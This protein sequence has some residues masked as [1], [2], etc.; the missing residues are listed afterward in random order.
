LDFNILCIFVDVISIQKTGEHFR[1]I[2][3]VKGRFTIHRITPEEA[4]VIK[5]NING[6]YK[7]WLT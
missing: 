7:H 2:Y 5:L 4:K 1:L 6:C 3:D